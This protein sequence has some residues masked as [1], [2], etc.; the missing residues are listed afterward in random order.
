M[1]HGG[2]GLAGFF[3]ISKLLV[4]Q[5]LRR[6]QGVPDYFWK[7]FLR[8]FPGLIVVTFLTV[9][10]G[11]FVY[12]S[13]LH[14]YIRNRSVWT[15]IPRNSAW[16]SFS[17][18]SRVF[19]RITRYQARSTGRCGPS[20]REVAC[21][22]MLASLRFFP[23]RADKLLLGLALGGLL[24]MRFLFEHALTAHCPMITGPMYLCIIFFCGSLLASLNL[25]SWNKTLRRC[26]LAA[27]LVGLIASLA[28]GR[29]LYFEWLT[30]TPLILLLGTSSTPGLKRP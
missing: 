3:S 11:V 20:G 2:R 19:L 13:S 17:T 21:Y 30:V 22:I 12:E 1:G 26:V 6:S 8:I 18:Q 25:E 4:Y 29:F 23:V 5:S 10:L 28:S 24:V 15:Y 27:S 7:R 9:G 16:V 14:D